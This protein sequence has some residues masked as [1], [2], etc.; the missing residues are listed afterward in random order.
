MKAK[1]E[2]VITHLDNGRRK[3]DRESFD[4]TYNE[5]VNTDNNET[6]RYIQWS[7]FILE[8]M[9]VVALFWK[10]RSLEVLPVDYQWIYVLIAVIF[11]IIMCLTFRVK[12]LNILISFL[13]IVISVGCTIFLFSLFEIDN[14]IEK[15]TSDTFYET[16][17]M[18]VVV[19]NKDSAKDIED[20]SGYDIG[21]VQS[22]EQVG[23]LIAKIDDKVSKEVNYSASNNFIVLADSLLK[24][25]EQAMLINNVYMDIIKE[26]EGYDDFTDRVKVLYTLDVKVESEV[27]DKEKL[28]TDNDNFIIYLSGIDSYGTVNVKSRSDVNIIAVVNKSKGKIQLINT[29]RDYF[30]EL[31]ISSG[32]L[33]KLTHAGIYGVNISVETLEKLYDIDID[34]FFRINFSGFEQIIDELGGIN[35]YSQYAFNGAEGSY[36]KGMNR[37]SGRQALGFARERYAFLQGDVQRGNNQMEVI[38]AVVNKMTSTDFLKNYEEVMNQLSGCFQTD[39]HSKTIY[40]LVREQLASNTSWEIESLSVTGTSAAKKTFSMPTVSSYVMIPSTIDIKKAK[41]MIKETLED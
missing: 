22:D 35:V 33:D 11:N 31:P 17:Q 9:L 30:V 16:V 2:K 41:R 21:Y 24:G 18:S 12:I 4:Y 37:L 25:R 32:K 23:E 15:V 8:V 28:S 39:M 26:V 34:Y 7:L 38:K 13:S 29:P 1:E 19:P 5:V 6:I 36:K 14:T 27:K 20:L 10:I 40:S 3:L